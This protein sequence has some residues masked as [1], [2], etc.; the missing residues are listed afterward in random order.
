MVKEAV[1]HDGYALLFA[2]EE[3]QSDKDVVM[4]AVRQDGRALELACKDLQRKKVVMEAV[5]Q[6]G[7]QCAA[8]C[9]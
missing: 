6:H 3:L 8:I 5:R 9:F 2:S 7:W 4:V 1:R